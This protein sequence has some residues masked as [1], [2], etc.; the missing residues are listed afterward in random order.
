MSGMRFLPLFL[1]LGVPARAGVVARV[2]LGAFAAPH[3]APA[4][5]TTVAPFA[6]ALV[7]PGFGTAVIPVPVSAAVPVE[8]KSGP[9][10][11]AV[12]AQAVAGLPKEASA[13]GPTLEKLYS[14]SDASSEYAA[15]F[16]QDD[17]LPEARMRELRGM[18]V[19]FVGG[20]LSDRVKLGRT[21]DPFHLLGLGDYFTGS[22]LWLRSQGVNAR[23]VR[24]QTESAPAD[25]ARRVAA[26]IRTSDKPVVLVTHSKGGIDSLVALLD[27]PEL[28]AKVRGWVALQ[29]PFAG[30]PIADAV[31]EKPWLRAAAD[32]LLNWFGGGVESLRSLTTRV[33]RDY[34]RRRAAEIA[35]LAAAVPILSFASYQDPAGLREETVFYFA[36]NMLA[37]KG[38]KSD[39]LV[40]VA[41]AVLPGSDFVVAPGLDHLIVLRRSLRR[42]FDQVRLTRALIG[43]VLRRAISDPRK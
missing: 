40:P 35:E 30:S 27:E 3:L 28:R 34:L 11:A 22:M 31:W 39:G 42:D 7:V 8:V 43:M 24:L 15:A 1:L 14:G 36:R 26:A 6:S 29:A 5:L 33:R 19:L 17:A 16:A 23:R 13:A 10:A 37:K 32:R 21:V 25:N 4:P 41:S 9:A 2:E 20:Y 38:H 12:L 18:R